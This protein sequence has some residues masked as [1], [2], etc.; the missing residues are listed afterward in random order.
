MPVEVPLIDVDEDLFFRGVGVEG[1]PVRASEFVHMRRHR[2]HLTDRGRK[3]AAR[4]RD[5][6]GEVG[7]V[8]WGNTAPPVD[9]LRKQRRL[10]PEL[11]SDSFHG[12]IAVAQR[13]AFET[14][15][16]D[17]GR[18]DE[19]AVPGWGQGS[20]GSCDFSVVGDFDCEARVV[21]KRLAVV[22]VVPLNNE[23]VASVHL[24][25][26]SLREGDRTGARR[27]TGDGGK[28]FASDLGDGLTVPTRCAV[29]AVER[30]GIGT[31][32]SGKYGD[33]AVMQHPG[34]VD[35]SFDRGHP[36]GVGEFWVDDPAAVVVEL[37]RAGVRPVGCENEIGVDGR[38]GL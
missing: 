18:P 36:R 32:V 29:R 21:G 8:L 7:E 33:D 24:D 22:V 23:C 5:S 11:F 20:S 10:E 13:S 12:G 25:S 27:P 16:R 38:K 28:E 35:A 34:L 3:I 1:Q 26:G 19:V 30:I 17:F 4:T 37:V 14:R 31:E 15:T 9:D 2:D 6:I